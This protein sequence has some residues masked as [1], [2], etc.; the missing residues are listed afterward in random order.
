MAPT[1]GDP[2]NPLKSVLALKGPQWAPQWPKKG[3]KSAQWRP[4]V[5]KRSPKAHFWGASGPLFQGKLPRGLPCENIS[6]YCGLN[7]LN[8]V[9]GV[10]LGTKNDTWN[11]Y[12]TQTS[13]FHNFST[14]RGAPGAPKGRKVGPRVSQRLPR[15]TQNPPKIDEKSTLGA[16]GAPKWPQ[17]WVPPSKLI[18]QLITNH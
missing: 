12:A 17:G 3:L 5:P 15:D 7:T 10:T 13:I 4:K 1:P 8:R 14:F 2:R 16:L 9:W 6:I 18:P 11:A